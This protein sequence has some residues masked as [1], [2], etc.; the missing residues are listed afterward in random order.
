MDPQGPYQQQP[1][2][3]TPSFSQMEPHS[4]QNAPQPINPPLPQPT[5][6]LHNP[7]AH[8]ANVGDKIEQVIMLSYFFVAALLGFR[9]ALGL[10]GASTTSPFVQFVHDI[11]IPFMIPF[12]GMFGIT[13]T[14]GYYS[15]EFEALIAI[16]VYALIFF[17]LGR[18]VKILFK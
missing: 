8:S 2:H 14:V 3:P 15:L 4:M 11:S 10:F 1:Y 7:I 18:L 13:P 17:G 12:E 9:F 6:P 5:P 16:I